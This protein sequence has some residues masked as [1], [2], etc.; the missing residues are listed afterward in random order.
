MQNNRSLKNVKLA[1]DINDSSSDELILLILSKC[2]MWLKTVCEIDTD[3]PAPLVSVAEDIAVIKYNMQGSEA[4]AS[5]KI[6][7]VYMNYD[8]LPSHIKDTI[9]LYK[10][11]R[12]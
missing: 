7:P 9:R 5:E 11:V 4:L 6:G 1:L 2:E 3:L 8:A 10:K 12:F